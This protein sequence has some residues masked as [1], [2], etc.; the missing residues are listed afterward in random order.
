MAR[1]APRLALLLLLLLAGSARAEGPTVFVF[2]TSW[3]AHCVSSFEELRALDR[4][5]STAGG[6]LVMVSLDA[7]E[8]AV[9]RQQLRRLDPPGAL[10]CDGKGFGG[11]LARSMRVKAVPA[12]RVVSGDGSVR[13]V[14]SIEELRGIRGRDGA[15][16]ERP[17]RR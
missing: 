7:G 5:L 13:A 15:R 6:R 10:A 12:Y 14:A 3:C 16:E 8:P 1:T 4:E 11:R 9:L 17:A 2:W